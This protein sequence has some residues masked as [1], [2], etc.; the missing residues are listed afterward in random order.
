MGGTWGHVHMQD[1]TPAL[2]HLILPVSF[3]GAWFDT[4]WIPFLLPPDPHSLTLL[5]PVN[6][7]SPCLSLWGDISSFVNDAG[8]QGAP[9][10]LSTGFY[11]PSHEAP[12]PGE[13]SESWRT[14]ELTMWLGFE[15]GQCVLYAHRDWLEVV[16]KVT[17]AHKNNT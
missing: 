8:G 15:Y 7:L 11:E 4:L 17:H 12:A 5:S 14:T 10:E 2:S 13:R 16:R 6:P 3:W 9:E 1:I